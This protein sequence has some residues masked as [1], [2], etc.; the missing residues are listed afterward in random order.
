MKRIIMLMT[1]AALWSACNSG[2]GSTTNTDSLKAKSETSSDSTKSQ[3]EA[4]AETRFSGST[5][6][7]PLALKTARLFHVTHEGFNFSIAA[8]GSGVGITD[9]E[10]DATDI[11]MSS[12]DMTDAERKV[13]E[14][15]KEPITEVK[16]ANDALAVVVHPGNGVDKLT[17][18]QLEKIFSGAVTNWKE[19]GGKDEKITVISR[20][21]TSGTYGF[22][23][24]AVLKSKD[25]AKTAE[26]V[27]SN[28][29]VKNKV[30]TTEGAIGYVGLAFLNDKV[31]ALPISFDGKNYIAPDI[32]D[33]K[34]KTYPLTRHLYL[35]YHNSYADQVK[36]FID[37]LLSA[38]GQ[39]EIEEIGY[40]SIN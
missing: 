10:N 24:D 18:E 19:L 9:L 8:Q 32:A 2:Q 12:R 30:S 6:V 22:F 5:T 16:I 11:A 28:D 20:E 1:S 14:D 29:I 34:N 7:A 26:E 13:F 23:K 27:A 15:K 21:T 39:K 35:I 3:T 33:V 38:D 17:R 31:K 25:F 37:Y 40:F 4:G 36:P